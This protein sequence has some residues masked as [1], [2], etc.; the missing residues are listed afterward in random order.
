MRKVVLFRATMVAVAVFATASFSVKP[1]AALTP[2]TIAPAEQASAPVSKMKT[3]SC[4]PSSTSSAALMQKASFIASNDGYDPAI[5]QSILLQETDAGRA[6]NFRVSNSGSNAVFGVMQLKL[7]AAKDVLEHFPSLYKKY[8]F[9]T[10]SAD[11]I[12]A[13]LILNDSFN[14][15]IA[16]KY[17]VILKSRYNI[18]DDN[19]LAAYNRGPNA[20]HSESQY[21]AE[22][23]QKLQKYQNR[24]QRI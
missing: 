17:L 6:S 12:K 3:S 7:D 14:I 13:N 20:N 10:R 18:A 15:E 21:A 22:A 24:Q 1:S 11:E 9:S 16:S 2:R 4:L 19:L 5:L 8:N 23:M